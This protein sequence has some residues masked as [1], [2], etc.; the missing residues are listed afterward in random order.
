MP[1]RSKRRA[2][3]LIVLALIGTALVAWNRIRKWTMPAPPR[4][5]EATFAQAKRVTIIRDAYGV[6]HVYGK[7][8]ADAAFGLA[9]ANAED[10]FPIIQ[11]VLAAATGRLGLLVASKRAL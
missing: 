11:A 10:D 4:P 7:G 9:Y 5:D 8:D 1:S 2:R 3:V 6:P